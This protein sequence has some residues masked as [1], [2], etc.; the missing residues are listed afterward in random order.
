MVG[1]SI[2]AAKWPNWGNRETL[3]PRNAGLDENEIHTIADEILSS[4]GCCIN[5]KPYI[6]RHEEGTVD[7][8]PQQQSTELIRWGC[9]YLSFKTCSK[10]I[11]T[12]R[13]LQAQAIFQGSKSFFYYNSITFELY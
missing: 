2:K 6:F 11:H 12:E 13:S 8:Y 4:D 5:V 10:Y 9:S 1:N 3:I 7:N